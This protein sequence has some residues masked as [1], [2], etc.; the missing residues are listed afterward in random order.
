MGTPS[1]WQISGKWWQYGKDRENWMRKGYQVKAKKEFFNNQNQTKMKKE[2][3]I[4]AGILLVVA[5]ACTNGEKPAE[6]QVVT[7]T[8]TKTEVVQVPAEVDTAAIIAFYAAQDAKVKAKA[9]PNTKT[10]KQGTK[11][12]SVDSDPIFVTTDVMTPAAPAAE[13]APANQAAPAPEV[14]V[15]HDVQM[16]YYIPDESASFPG[17]EKAF[18]K[19]LID[20]LQYPERAWEEGRSRTVYP[21]LFL[22]EQG[23]PVNVEFRYE[24]TVYGFQDEAR[25]I[26]MN[27][28]RWN[29]AKVNGQP[30]KSKVTIP[31]SFN[32]AN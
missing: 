25:R 8:V 26:L 16:Y 9:T 18:D 12:V 17:G 22:D 4:Y 13:A 7:D 30:V 24:P 6:V 15:V 14:K 11:T 27:S 29:P 2:V 3:F 31:I 23:N 10:K 32:I 5:Q 1:L 28:P 21:T 20:N 19:Y